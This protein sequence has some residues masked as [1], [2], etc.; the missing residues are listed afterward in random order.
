MNQVDIE[1][2]VK[3][4]AGSGFRVVKGD[5]FASSRCRPPLVGWCETH[6]PD[7]LQCPSYILLRHKNVDI[8]ETSRRRAAECQRREHRTFEHQCRYFCVLQHFA[9]L[10]E[11]C[12]QC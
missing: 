1:F 10:N 8:T 2:P 11:I 5:I 9:D 4:N 3:L 6:S 12:S 7:T